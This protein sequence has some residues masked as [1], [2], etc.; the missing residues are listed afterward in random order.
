MSFLTNP[1][2]GAI[3]TALGGPLNGAIQAATQQASMKAGK[4][5]VAGTTPREFRYHAS[6]KSPS[7]P[8]GR[9]STAGGNNLNLPG[10]MSPDVLMHP[11]VQKL[12]GQYGVTPA[13]IQG[14]IQNAS[15]NLFLPE[16]FTQA[17]PRLGGM[18]EH[19]LEGAVFTQQG[20]TTGENIVNALRAPL[21]AR[22]A[23]AEKYNNQ[24]MM[25]FAQ[26]QQV[27]NLQG[28]NLQQEFERA[29]TAKATAMEGYYDQ[30]PEIKKMLL[31]T[32]QQRE[33]DV[34]RFHNQEMNWHMAKDAPA[35]NDA[36]SAELK[37]LTDAAGGDLY[38]IDNGALMDLYGRAR[39]RALQEN[40]AN[41]KD[42][43]GIAG[44]AR[45]KSAEVNKAGSANN[46]ALKPYEDA[47]K[48]AQ[49]DYDRFDKALNAGVAND[50]TGAMVIKGSAKATAEKARLAALRDQAQKDWI[51]ATKQ[52][53]TSVSPGTGS[54]STP[55]QG[56][57]KKFVWDGQKL[58]PKQQG[59]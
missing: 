27:A 39:N 17:H 48:S 52:S 6:T 13:A 11:E 18:L 8:T 7:A 21:L 58:V 45:I 2:V 15:P 57:K 3:D 40:L 29:Q 4:S 12:L 50:A 36:E 9:G 56:G 44:G 23:S 28:T 55:A 16:H 20:S 38:D 53:G 37:Q 47:Y 42:V 32:Q 25:P 41:K 5:D 59:K 43:A 26:A 30:L 49:A 24:L 22:Q 46:P 31:E 10:V 19:A 34:R 54:N 14:S 1:I 51:A 35:L 33:N